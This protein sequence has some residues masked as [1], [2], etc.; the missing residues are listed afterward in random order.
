[1]DRQILE[2]LLRLR[3][4]RRTKARDFASR[5]RRPGYSAL[6]GVTHYNGMLVAFALLR[7]YPQLFAACL[8]ARAC[9]YASF[10]YLPTL[11]TLLRLALRDA[12]EKLEEPVICLSLGKLGFT[13]LTLARPCDK[14]TSAARRVSLSHGDCLR[15]RT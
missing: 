5:L 9:E 14:R 1:M 4:V 2:L 12:D 13:Q 6:H 11:H 8:V 15:G 10:R 7:C 3:P